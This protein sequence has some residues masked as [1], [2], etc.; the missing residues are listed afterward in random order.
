MTAWGNNI[1]Y[2][3]GTHLI[4]H[5]NGSVVDPNTGQLVHDFTAFPTSQLGVM[6]PDS[7]L[8][9]AFFVYQT[10]TL[11]ELTIESFDATEFTSIA[12]TP[13]NNVFGTPLRIIRWGKNGLAFNTYDAIYGIYKVFV[14]SGSIVANGINAAGNG[15]GHSQAQS[16]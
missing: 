6:V 11:Y 1:H 16:R 15:S 13:I 12:Q 4:Y 10:G 3:P 2:D 8:N 7:T 14:V 9:R 5:D